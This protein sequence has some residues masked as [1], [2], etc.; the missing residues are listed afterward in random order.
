MNVN[1]IPGDV[2]AGSGMS[3]T[4]P[5]R[6]AGGPSFQ[7]QLRESALRFT[8]HAEERLQ[9]RSISLDGRDM[10]RLEEAVRAAESKGAVNSLVLMDG[11]ALVVNVATRNVVTACEREALRDGVF[12]NIDSAVIVRGS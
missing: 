11:L 10:A 12:T 7:E 1:G 9:R 6:A 5:S 3:A 2:A 8:R 4:R